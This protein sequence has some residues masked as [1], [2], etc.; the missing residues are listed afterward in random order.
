MLES[1]STCAHRDD[2]PFHWSH[3]QLTVQQASPLTLRAGYAVDQVV[4]SEYVPFPVWSQ[5]SRYWNSLHK[6]WE[7][8]NMVVESGKYDL[9]EGLLQ[10]L[11][12]VIEHYQ[13]WRPRPDYLL[14]FLV[15]VQ[16]S[17]WSLEL[18]IHLFK[19]HDVPDRVGLKLQ[20]CRHAEFDWLLQPCTLAVLWELAPYLFLPISESCSHRCKSSLRCAFLSSHVKMP[21]LS[22]IFHSWRVPLLW[23]ISK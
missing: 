11:N 17:S 20:K 8:E 6:C 7:M 10:E 2:T 14:T 21:A 12:C 5:L 22:I 9:V 16:E 15:G 4:G 1:A 19:I 23:R 3:S 13:K 18:G